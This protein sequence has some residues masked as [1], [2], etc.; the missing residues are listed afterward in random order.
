MPIYPHYKYWSLHHNLVS[1]K[2]QDLSASKKWY[3]L[4]L[5][6]IL[7]HT[8]QHQY[9]QKFW[10]NTADS[11]SLQWI[12]KSMQIMPP[13]IQT[14]EGVIMDAYT[15]SLAPMT[16]NTI[17]YKNSFTH[18]IH[19]NSHHWHWQKQLTNKYTEQWNFLT[20]ENPLPVLL[21]FWQG[22]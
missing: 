20:A 6:K 8:S 19:G 15:L 18:I 10:G 7:L 2:G 13:Y 17:K 4:K 16:K 21:Q 12:N 11:S 9:Y 22:Y 1:G 3:K 5:L 14:W